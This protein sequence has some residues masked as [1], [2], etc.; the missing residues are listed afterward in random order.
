M[1]APPSSRSSPPPLSSLS[2]DALES[3]YRGPR[4]VL[5]FGR[6]TGRFLCFL[7]SEGGR[8]PRYRALSTV[9]FRWPRWGVDLDR[10]LWWFGLPALALGHFRPEPSTS[11][12]RNA[13]VFQLHYDP[14]R[15]PQA[16]RGQLYDEIKPLA[17]GRILGIGGIGG[18]ATAGGPRDL[19]FFELVADRG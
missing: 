11:A 2:V 1:A 9:M 19:F 13:D 7:D 6:H 14:S 3:L 12:W 8:D 10:R 18:P 16:V 5:P 4:G 17:D 15:L